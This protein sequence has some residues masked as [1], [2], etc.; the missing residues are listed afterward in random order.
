MSSRQMKEK[1]RQLVFS[2]VCLKLLQV[3]LLEQIVFEVCP[4][5]VTFPYFADS[6]S[7]PSWRVSMKY[8]KM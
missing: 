4:F 6:C 1:N 2:E 7:K 8:I 3:I 5:L